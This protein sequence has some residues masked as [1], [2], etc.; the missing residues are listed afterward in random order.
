MIVRDKQ[1]EEKT[2]LKLITEFSLLNDTAIP[3]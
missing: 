2:R 1:A 3:L